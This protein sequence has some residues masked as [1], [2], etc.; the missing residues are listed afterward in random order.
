MGRRRK[1]YGAFTILQRAVV[2]SVLSN[3]RPRRN[4]VR[5][6]N[7]D[8]KRWATSAT[9]LSYQIF[10]VHLLGERGGG[11]GGGELSLDG[12]AG[13]IVVH[14]GGVFHGVGVAIRVPIGLDALLH[15]LG[16]GD[17]GVDLRGFLDEDLDSGLLLRARVGR[18][19]FGAG[20]VGG[21]GRAGGSGS[22]GGDRRRLIR[23]GD[24][25]RA[26]V[27]IIILAVFRN[28]GGFHTCSVG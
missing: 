17:D 7:K 26:D 18:L 24:G 22:G 9:F 15:D 5:F 19:R 25:S 14:M 12:S 13:G 11:D 4:R 21:V 16:V 20:R 10:C 6:E 2:R 1:C 23:F 27:F 28:R 3:T 8:E